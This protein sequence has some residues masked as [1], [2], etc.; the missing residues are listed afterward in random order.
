VQELQAALQ[1][2]L[3]SSAVITFEQNKFTFGR[4]HLMSPSGTPLH[5]S[6]RSKVVVVAVMLVEVKVVVLEVEAVGMHSSHKIKQLSRTIWSDSQLSTVNAAHASGSILPLQASVVVVVVERDVVVVV[7]VVVVID[8]VVVV[9]IDV[10]VVVPVLVVVV[11]LVTVVVV[12]VVVVVV[13][14]VVVV[15]NAQ[16]GFKM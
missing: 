16:A 3:Y 12:V 14:T 9:D 15:E 8:V 4:K 5:V 1:S 2:A 13:E 6:T 11:E 10:V 7:V